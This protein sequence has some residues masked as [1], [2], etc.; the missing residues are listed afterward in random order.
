MKKFLQKLVMLANAALQQK[1][2][3][4]AKGRHLMAQNTAD[5]INKNL[6]K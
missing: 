6:N 2:E 5:N 1:L 3:Q 4:S